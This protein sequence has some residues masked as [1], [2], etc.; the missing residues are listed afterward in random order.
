MYMKLKF[1]FLDS[2]RTYTHARHATRT[3]AHTLTHTHARTHATHT[4]MH[5]HGQS[6]AHTPIWHTLTHNHGWCYKLQISVRATFKIKT[7][8]SNDYN[9]STNLLICYT[10]SNMFICGFWRRLFYVR[11]FGIG[12][13]VLLSRALYRRRLFL[14]KRLFL[15]FL[16]CFSLISR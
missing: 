2:V 11:S 13:V 7:A 9:T 15:V 14:G 5:A 12:G 6:Y 10:S 16:A 4:Y 3:Y 1:W 8:V